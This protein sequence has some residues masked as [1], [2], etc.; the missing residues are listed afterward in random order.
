MGC[1]AV[2]VVQPPKRVLLSS[3]QRS[4]RNSCKETLLVR[5]TS[6]MQR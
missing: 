5:S 6:T 1:F 2:F 3:L 4:Y